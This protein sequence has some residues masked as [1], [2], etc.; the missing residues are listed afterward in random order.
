MS[1]T[2]PRI[3]PNQSGTIRF[4]VTFNGLMLNTKEG[5]LKNFEEPNSCWSPLTSIV[6]KEMLW[7][8]MRPSTVWLPAFFRISSFMFI[9][10]EKLIQV[11]NDR[12]VIYMMTVFISGWTIPLNGYILSSAHVYDLAICLSV[13][14]KHIYK[15]LK[16]WLLVENCENNTLLVPE[17]IYWSSRWPTRGTQRII[18]RVCRIP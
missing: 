7:K 13:A 1:F 17:I 4:Y 3:V 14:H 10:R 11:W 16:K 18:W 2:H 6:R 12:R 9:M 15:K 5:I 8:S